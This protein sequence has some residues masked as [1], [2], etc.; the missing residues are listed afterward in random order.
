[1]FVGPAGSG[2]SSLVAAYSKWLRECGFQV[3]IVSLDPAADY[4]PYTPDLD[5]R[6]S[7]DAR[8]VAVKY[9][10]GPNAAL[11]KS[12]ELIVRNLSDILSPITTIDADF[13]LIDTPGQL[14][15]FLFRDLSVRLSEWL[16]K[17]S[18]EAYA[19]F[20]F[21]ATLLRDPADYAF[22]QLLSLA[23]QLRLGLDTAPVINKID[24]ARDIDYRG[25]LLRDLGK[26]R[27]RL[28][29][30]HSLYAEMLRDLLRELLE[31]ARSVNV[32]RV[33][34]KTG[35]GIEDLHKLLHEMG[36]ACGDLS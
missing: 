24:L 9:G 18:S 11:V 33:S 1:M 22:M 8:E 20:V 5:V 30:K 19:I 34:A 3:Y 26:L 28:L 36:C 4:L 15:V 21:D 17:Y 12:I 6:G 25:D 10:L 27:K 14:E 31:Y 7:I 13:I 23:T 32:P 29:E 16:K 2:K 35:E